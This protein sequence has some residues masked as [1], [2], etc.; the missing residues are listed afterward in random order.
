MVFVLSLLI[1]GLSCT[2]GTDENGCSL[3]KSNTDPL[4]LPWR[5]V[6]QSRVTDMSADG[7]PITGRIVHVTDCGSSNLAGYHIQNN[8]VSE[9]TI[10]AI[11]FYS[12]FDERQAISHFNVKTNG[13]SSDY[14]L[15]LNGDG[16]CEVAVVYSH[17]DSLWLEVF[18]PHR[19]RLTRQ[20][21]V[22]GEDRDRNGRWDGGGLVLGHCD[23]DRNGVIELLVRVDTGYDLYPRQLMCIDVFGQETLWAFPHAGIISN[24]NFYIEPLGEGAEPLAVFG[25]SSKGNAAKSPGMDDQHAYVVAVDHNGKLMW[26]YE[27]GGVFSRSLPVVVDFDGDGLR[28]VVVPCVPGIPSNGDSVSIPRGPQFL[29]ISMSGQVIDSIPT[30]TDAII[31]SLIQ[32]DIND[33]GRDEIIALFSDKCLVV[34]NQHLNIIKKI[35]LTSQAELLAIADIL[36]NGHRQILLTTNDSR[37]LLLD[38][39]LSLLAQLTLD[40]K[41]QVNR[42]CLGE[43]V[44]ENGPVSLV[45]AADRGRIHYILG[46]SERHWSTVFIRRPKL[47]I[48]VTLL[49][50]TLVIL[51]LIVAW[52]RI[53]HKNQLISHQR[54][55]L[56]EE[57]GKLKHRVEERTAELSALNKELQYEIAK[58]KEAEDRLVKLGRAF[59]YAMDEIAVVDMDGYIQNVNESWARAHG[60]SQDELIGKNLSIFHTKEQFEEEVVSFGQEARRTGEWEGEAWHLRKDGSTFLMS[61][62]C[63]LIFDEQDKPIAILAIGRDITERKALEKELQQSVSRF[64]STLSSM[65]DLVF[66]VDREGVFVEYYQPRNAR[67][68]YAPPEVFMGKS[69]NAMLP[70]EVADNFES[71][72][73][74]VSNTNEVQEIDY[75]LK[76]DGKE[77]WFAAKISPR[78]DGNNELTGF[79]VV[80][81]DI[82]DRRKVDKALRVSEERFRDLVNLLPQSVFEISLEGN[83]TFANLSALDSFGYNQEDVESGINIRS[84]IVPEDKDR[85]IA[86]I[87]KRLSGGALENHEYTALRKDGSTFYALIYSGVIV[88]D[89]V[90]AG[91]RGVIIDIS[92]RKEAED[93]LREN[94]NRLTGIFS[95]LHEAMIVVVDKQNTYL[96]VWMPKELEE[97]YGFRAIDLVGKDWRDFCTLEEAKERTK[98]LHYIFKTKKPVREE[99][100]VRIPTGGNFWHDISLSPILSDAGEVTAVVGFISDITERKESRDQLEASEERYRELFDSVVEGLARVDENEI[101]QFCNPAFADILDEDSVEDVV[102]KSLLYYLS[103]DQREILLSQTKQRREGI[104]SS[105]ELMIKTA[106]GVEK[107]IFVSVA[108]RY[109]D[110]GD[111]I[112]AFGTV[113]DI[114]DK[115]LAE[116]EARHTNQI[117]Y[118]QIREIAGGVSHEI[119]NSLYPA[120]VALDKLHQELTR[121]PENHRT[122]QQKLIQ[123]SSQAVERAIN[124]TELVTEYARLESKKEKETVN[125][126]NVI[127]SILDEQNHRIEELGVTCSVEI[128]DDILCFCNETHIHSV[129][130]NL[131][132]N[133]LDAM[134][135]V[136]HR[137]ITISGELQDEKIR[138]KVA[139]TGS[140]IPAEILS[141]VFDPFFSTKPHTG[142]GLGLAIVKKI[143]ELYGGK[144]TVQSSLDKGTEFIIFI[145]AASK[146]SS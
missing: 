59:D 108:P 47:L 58:Q 84:L 40:A 139:D 140:G 41:P 109:D 142:T 77:R 15:D 66:V 25:I 141:K 129:F 9:D 126:K 93:A 123:M 65:D 39:D 61:M 91:L 137:Q 27:V 4:S 94:E 97:R 29:V 70:A 121:A 114:T 110:K 138:I 63:S 128:P 57:R 107:I 6:I 32:T 34:Y 96:S 135:D 85:I 103:D 17:L 145:E 127:D 133:A 1:A 88:R 26:K 71:T 89:G 124:M 43:R 115:K 130:S 62:A 54:D 79:T 5:F 13:I 113:L 146:S 87:Q 80:I 11:V 136:D 131:I 3:I 83:V 95:S 101:I 106:K 31:Y 8:W 90:T 44:T 53:R 76:M 51:I 72:F 120:V 24:C 99:Y 38:H 16:V 28:D 73:D 45:L 68:L 143:V 21:L 122:K 19:G 100:K 52:L 117:R 81:R 56:H 112:G 69:Y 86:S 23:I 82:S 7:S 92:D 49:P 46:L 102:G 50:S 37:L 119:C 98:V 125:I 12:D 10:T 33:D 55:A 14:H 35:R 134:T 75:S 116:D 36:G 67:S 20:L 105:Y 111:Y 18:D 104:S 78:L 64:E 42:S 60:Y 48:L 144:V 118:N 22:V 132:I 2:P 74:V 30:N